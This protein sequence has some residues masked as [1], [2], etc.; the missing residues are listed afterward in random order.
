MVDTLD[1][2]TQGKNR[3]RPQPTPKRHIRS[4]P[5][6]RLLLR[7]SL[8]FLGNGTP[9]E[10]AIVR[11]AVF[12]NTTDSRFSSPSPAASGQVVRG[13]VLITTGGNSSRFRPRVVFPFRAAIGKTPRSLSCSQHAPVTLARALAIL[14]A[15][16]HVVKQ[17]RRSDA[18]VARQY[19]SEGIMFTDDAILSDQSS[20]SYVIL[21]MLRGCSSVWGPTT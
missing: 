20:T 15:I 1:E 9:H 17:G 8:D 18:A 3:A 21:T 2:P 4:R 16:L 5:G 11:I 12:P 19:E 6:F 10:L 7:N 14:L 13:I